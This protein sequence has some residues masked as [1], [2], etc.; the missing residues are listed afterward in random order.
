LYLF[1]KIYSLDLN[2]PFQAK[3]CSPR[4]ILTL[5]AYGSAGQGCVTTLVLVTHQ[6][7]LF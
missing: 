6:R 7:D 3:R 1:S 5:Y 4:N 2:I